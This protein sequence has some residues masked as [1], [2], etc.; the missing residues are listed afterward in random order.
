MNL[1]KFVDNRFQ[2]LRVQEQEEDARKEY[3]LPRDAE[4]QALQWILSTYRTLV[5]WLMVPKVLFNFAWMKTGIGREPQP[6]LIR[7][8]E[9]ERQKDVNKKAQKLGMMEKIKAVPSTG[10]QPLPN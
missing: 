8:M 6:V 2:E 10:E 4:V 1:V 9:A 7:K 5:K 3:C